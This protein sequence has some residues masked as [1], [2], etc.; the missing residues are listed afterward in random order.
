MTD[1][2]KIIDDVNYKWFD[3]EE[4]ISN[5]LHKKASTKLQFKFLLDETYNVLQKKD[6]TNRL[7]VEY[8]FMKT[9]AWYLFYIA[10]ET[11]YH[12]V[13]SEKDKYLIWL[14]KHYPKY[15]KNKY[16]SPFRPE[17]ESFKNRLAVYLLM[18]GKLLHI[19]N[20]ILKI[21]K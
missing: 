5:T 9:I 8:F 21:F 17:G 20:V 4:S 1:K 6:Y 15:Q 3:N 14:K 2:I 13:V 16:L 18:K 12:K 10:K 11:P 7:I 19:D